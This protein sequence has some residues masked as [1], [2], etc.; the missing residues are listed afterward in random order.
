[1][2][3]SDHTGSL[4]RRQP[5]AQIGVVDMHLSFVLPQLVLCF[6][7]SHIASM[8]IL[9]AH[10]D[11]NLP[12]LTVPAVPHLPILCSLLQHHSDLSH[13]LSSHRELESNSINT[14]IIIIQTCLV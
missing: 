6:L 12:H 8:P 2:F 4:L 1:M 10:V 3:F 5:G 14:V 9:W 7:P 13:V 11:L